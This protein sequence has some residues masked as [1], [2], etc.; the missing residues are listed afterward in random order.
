MRSTVVTE[1]VEGDVLPRDHFGRS[2]RRLVASVAA[3][4]LVTGV[5]LAVGVFWSS[6]GR[7]FVIR[8]PSMGTAAPVGALV[9]TRPTRVHELHVGDVVSFHPV[10][11]AAFTYTHRIVAVNN[12]AVTTRGDINGSDDPWRTTDRELV[13]RVTLV[14]PG[15]GY[16]ARALPLLLVGG[17]VVVALTR[18]WLEPDRRGPVRLLGFTVL[19]AVASLV[20]HPFVGLVQLETTSGPDGAVITAVSTGLLPVTVL[21]LPGH[22]TGDSV[23]LG[24]GEVGTVH[25]AKT[26][27]SSRYAIMA[28]LDLSWGGWLL[29]A[30]VWL[31]PSLWVFG[32]GFRRHPHPAFE[33]GLSD[34]ASPAIA[35][36]T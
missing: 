14:V 25:F 29:L 24:A 30:L 33:V 34:A 9:L 3:A 10:G 8:T 2:T 20:I 18:W 7:W 13:G 19:Y 5:L 17:T 26:G 11:A 16:L 28:E 32:I 36:P 15:L 6:G 31:A 27:G 35:M 23:H 4:V 12:N 22:G 21:P 1:P